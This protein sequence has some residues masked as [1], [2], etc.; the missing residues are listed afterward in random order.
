MTRPLTGDK[1]EIAVLN[2]ELRGFS[3]LIDTWK[4]EAERCARSIE[5]VRD[6]HKPFTYEKN[7]ETIVSDICEG[8]EQCW[9]CGENG[10]STYSD[11]SQCPCQ[12]YPCATI[13]ALDGEQ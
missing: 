12:M 2:A 6:L 9:G 8:C 10:G 5:R 11:G 13:K 1:F 7:G 3:E 4:E